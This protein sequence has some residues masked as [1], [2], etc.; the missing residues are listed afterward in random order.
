MAQ[1]RKKPVDLIG[2]AEKRHVSHRGGNM[3]H[4]RFPNGFTDLLM[5][6]TDREVSTLTDRAFRSLCV[7]DD[8]IYNDEFLYGYSPFSCHKPLAGEPLKKNHQKESKKQRKNDREKEKNISS[9]SSFLKALST[10][11]ENCERILL[12]NGGMADSNGESWDKSALRSIQRELSEFSS[13]Y[14]SNLVGGHDDKRTFHQSGYD[15]SSKGLFSGTS[16][17]MKNGKATVKLK[18]LNV[19]NFFLHS[20]FSP[21]RT[22]E[23]MNQFCFSHENV[24]ILPAEMTPKWYDLPFYKEL[25]EAHMK[26]TLHTQEILKEVAEP[27]APAPLPLPPPATPPA[28]PPPPPPPVAPKPVTSTSPPKVLPKPQKRCSS[29]IT[30]G[31]VVPW[32]QTHLSVKTAVPLKQEPQ[33]ESSTAKMDKNVS[34]M[35]NT[36]RPM[37]A[38]AVEELS[39]PVSTPFSICQLMTPLIPSRQPTETSEILS[40]ILSPSVLDLPHGPHSEAKLTPEPP[41]KRDGY[42]S[43]ASSILFNLKDN[44][45]RVKSRYSPPKFKTLEAPGNDTQ[46]PLLENL[47][48]QN[49]S[50]GDTCDFS[51]PAIS[52]E[53]QTVR[54][55]VVES[56]NPP[57]VGLSERAAD[58]SQSDDYLLSNLLHNKREALSNGNLGDENA[59]SQ[60]MDAKRNKSHTA[61][62]QSYPSLNLYKKASPPVLTHYSNELSLL[63]PS[64]AP[65]G[66]SPNINCGHSP[67]FT[68]SEHNQETLPLSE[69]IRKEPPNVRDK[70]NTPVKSLK[71]NYFGEESVSSKVKDS[72]GQAMSTLDVIRA[73]KEAINATKTRV[74]HAPQSESI[75]QAMSDREEC[76]DKDEMFVCSNVIIEKRNIAENDQV[77]S[78]SENVVKKEPPPVPKKNLPKPDIQQS[79][80]KKKTHLTNQLS[81]CDL[82]ETTPDSQDRLKHKFSDRLNNYIKCQRHTVTDEEHRDNEGDTKVNLRIEKDA[83]TD[84]EH[85]IH[86]LHAL[87]ELERAR[88]SDREHQAGGPN[89]DEVARAKNDLISR[90]LKNIKKG[91]LSMRGNTLAKRELFTMKEKQLSKQEVPTKKG[92][93]VMI[94]KALVNDNYD[95]AKLALEEVILSREMTRNKAMNQDANTAFAAY[96]TDGSYGSRVQASKN[97]MK[98]SIVEANKDKNY[99]TDKE[100]DLRERLGDLRDHKHMRQILSQTEPRQAETQRSDE[101]VAALPGMSNVDSGLNSPS[102]LDFKYANER[103]IDSSAH[104]SERDLNLKQFSENVA[105]RR[106]CDNQALETP[107]VPPRSKKAGNRR[108]ESSDKED[109]SNRDVEVNRIQNITSTKVALPANSNEEKSNVTINDAVTHDLYLPSKHSHGEKRYSLLSDIEANTETVENAPE[110]A[111]SRNIDRSLQP[112]SAAIHVLAE[113]LGKMPKGK[114]D[115]DAEALTR[116]IISP[117][118]LVNGVG[119]D[120]HTSMSSKSSYFSVES[121]PQRNAESILF[122]SLENLDK[123]GLDN[124]GDHLLGPIKKDSDKPGIEYYSFNDLEG[125]STIARESVKSEEENVNQKQ[126]K[127]HTT[128][129]PRP[130]QDEDIQNPMSPSN[131]LTPML[132]IPALFKI[133]DN[134]FSNKMK[135]TTQPWTPQGLMNNSEKLVEDLHPLNENSN[136]PSANETSPSFTSEVFKPEETLSIGSSPSMYPPLILQQ[137]KSGRPRKLVL[138][139]PQKENDSFSVVSPISERVETLTMP[140]TERDISKVPSER[141]GSTCSFNDSQSGFAKPPAVLPKSERAVL[142]AMKL[143]NRRIKKA[144]AQKSTPS[145]HRTDKSVPR[146]GEKKHHREGQKRGGNGNDAAVANNEEFPP[147]KAEM[148]QKTRQSSHDSIEG[149]RLTDGLATER[150]RSRGKQSRDKPEQR[151][152]S[153]DRLISTAPVYKLNA[154]PG[155]NIRSQSIDRYLGDRVGRRYRTD[156]SVNER[157]DPRS[158]RIEKSIVDEFQQRGRAKEKMLRE[159]P[160]RRSQSIDTHSLQPAQPPSLSR[161]LSQTGQFS[162]QSSIEHTGVTQSIPATQRK[163]LQDPDSGQYYFV[164]LPV[165]VQTKTFFDPE[166]GSYV[167]LPVQPP[168]GAVLQASPM[169][170]LSPPLVVYHGFVPVPLTPMAQNAP[171]Q[172]PHVEQEQRQLDM[173]RQVHCKDGHPYL[174]PVYGEHEHMLGE[175]LGT[176]EVDC[177]S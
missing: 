161:Q 138:P 162:R 131:T 78:E 122:H 48:Q 11:G 95:K 15:S 14:H 29:D 74:L 73:A 64:K 24:S 146:S 55:P 143:T 8:A 47:K 127:Q 100:K 147:K 17:K 75:N 128:K 149:T 33:D 3:L 90:E 154:G 174:E 27:P 119:I 1:N 25:T 52:K 159:K 57:T 71:E 105:G 99:T 98:D 110:E 137:E 114:S 103:R 104:W 87:K 155:P 160:L 67:I 141:S 69:S 28:P 89:L 94:N 85:I 171:I 150:G 123:A 18:K 97:V 144:E 142:K 86:D 117:E 66:L 38:K 26:E 80:S 83:T 72:R 61:K 22:W 81:N 21:F 112:D 101:R 175:F 63:N 140:T 126:S 168:D 84:S 65:P 132:D 151:H 46:S 23:G 79:L 107:S 16:S 19:K 44:R 32:R 157:L 68:A 134:T 96:A 93:S 172:V 10:T 6:E 173:S 59:N 166:T 5:D 111:T 76:K 30:D 45:K 42:K 139:A 39:P 43:L 177:P 125:E 164:D 136:P 158:T 40:A 88:L 120:D 54:S 92:G 12:K 13:D 58:G 41:I 34:L 124:R 129:C 148:T 145:K 50:E 170:V 56:V 130:S 60:I 7:G 9:M 116:T 62:K 163:L 4:H 152:C 156:T 118:L 167:Q 53:G 36:T 113:D 169:E 135:K 121:P 108:N 37:E 115:M 109:L 91:M 82:G 133:K 176:E 2:C 102:R 153:S 70:T 51:T 77:R 49:N 165:Q 31:S 106:I 35:P 20:E